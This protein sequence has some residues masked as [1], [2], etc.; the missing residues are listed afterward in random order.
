MIAFVA[1]ENQ[2]SGVGQA[3]AGGPMGFSVL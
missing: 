3:N 2:L 1:D